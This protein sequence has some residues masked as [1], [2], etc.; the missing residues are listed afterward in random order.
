MQILQPPTWP[1]PKGYSN[2]IMAEGKI[3]FVGGQIGWDESGAFPGSTLA[4]QVRLALTN[5]LA[6]LGEAGAKTEHIVR[7]TW[8]ITDKQ[9]YL[10]S[11][12]VVGEAYREIMGK[13]FPA[14]S[15]VQ[16]LALMED[17]AKVEIETTAVIPY[18]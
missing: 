11:I 18:K 6:V 5:T 8:F 13:H 15:M 4:D 16:V 14:M 12:K 7:M 1:K 9:E 10:D 3:V 17:E 2:G